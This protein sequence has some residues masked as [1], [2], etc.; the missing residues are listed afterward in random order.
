M[1][2]LLVLFTLILFLVI[3]HFVQKRRTQPAL[4]QR[5][6]RTHLPLPIQFPIHVPEGIS[7]ATNHTWLR[8]NQDGTVTIGLDEFLSRL[9]GA[10]EKVSIPREG[11]MIAPAI[12]DIA[13][14]VHGRSL[15]LAPPM[16]GDVVESNPEVLRNASL[17]LSDPYGRGWLL[18]VKSN[19]LRTNFLLMVGSSTDGPDAD[20]GVP[21]ADRGAAAICARPIRTTAYHKK[22]SLQTL[23]ISC[24]VRHNTWHD[25]KKFNGVM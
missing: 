18:R 5:Q 6:V 4:A 17:I 11:E 2:V 25:K 14:G 9:V 8:T 3:D 12:A 22:K 21:A 1:T 16:N 10:L 7:L 23:W 20:R 13:L 15:R 19:A 24:N